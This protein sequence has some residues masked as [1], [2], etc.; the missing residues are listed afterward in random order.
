MVAFDKSLEVELVLRDLASRGLRVAGSEVKKFAKESTAGAT[1]S[2]IAM[3]ALSVAVG[4]LSGTMLALAVGGLASMISGFGEATEEADELK[5]A[6]DALTQKSGFLQVEQADLAKAVDEAGLSGVKTA[7]AIEALNN[8]VSQALKGQNEFSEAF[9][10]AGVEL[11]DSRGQL[12]PFRDLLIQLFADIGTAKREKL[13]ESVLGPSLGS[14][15]SGAVKSLDEL[16][17]ALQKF[18]KD[19]KFFPQL[20]E[21]GFFPKVALQESRRR[22]ADFLQG[23]E[24]EARESKE[25]QKK[26][27]DDLVDAQKKIRDIIQATKN[28]ATLLREEEEKRKEA[29]EKAYEAGSLTIEQEQ[30]LLGLNEQAFRILKLKL[31][32]EQKITDEQRR[33]E[34]KSAIEQKQQEEDDKIR[35]NGS[36]VQNLELSIKKFKEINVEAVLAKGLIDN[37]TDEVSDGLAGAFIDAQQGVK[38]LQQGIADV[39]RQIGLEL[40]KL[41]IKEAILGILQAIIP[42]GGTAVKTGESIIKGQLATGGVIPGGG[43]PGYAGGGVATE[44]LFL[45]GEGKNAEAVVPLPDNRSIPVKFKG[46]AGGRA[47]TLNFNVNAIDSQSFQDALFQN[48]RVMTEIIRAAMANDVSMRSQVRS[49]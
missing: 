24:K 40:E 18:T 21:E 2:K 44:P 38:S 34:L 41:L 19:P 9:K 47:V 39:F 4:V 35:K 12:V 46:G 13:L 25:R 30:E 45:V 27:D 7:L 1:E 29:I 14:D 15:I 20:Q 26:I 10:K 28:P 43:V 16:N 32:A 37:L 42:G 31:E 23:V 36:L 33:R 3:K 22:F 17:I 11:R 5:A 8:A 6:L 49:L 48:R